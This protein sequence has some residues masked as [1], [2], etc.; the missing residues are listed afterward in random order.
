MGAL[1]YIFAL[2]LKRCNFMI[3]PLV[4]LSAHIVNAQVHNRQI[5]KIILYITF[6]I[7]IRKNYKKYNL[8]KRLVRLFSF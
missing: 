8:K 1:K 2:L 5:M 3:Y 4:T 7:Y 6:Q